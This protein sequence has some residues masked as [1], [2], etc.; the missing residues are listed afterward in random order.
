MKKN[1]INKENVDL[2]Q[3]F[4]DIVNK[5]K[6]SELEYE[7]DGLKIKIVNYIFFKI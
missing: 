7:A 5:D 2:V 3:T 6:L 4:V 1:N